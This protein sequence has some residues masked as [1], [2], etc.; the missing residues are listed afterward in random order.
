MRPDEDKTAAAD[1]GE[2]GVTADPR[3]PT[4]LAV[5]VLV[6]LLVAAGVGGYFLRQAIGEDAPQSVPQLASQQ[7]ERLTAVLEKDPD[8]V[9]ARLSLGYAHQSRQ[10]WDLALEQ[11]KAVAE[12]DPSNAGALYQQGVIYSALALDQE[13]EAAYWKVLEIDPEHVQAAI[14]LGRMYAEQ[15]NFRSIVS[16]VRPAVVAHP[17]SAE[18]QYLLGLAYEHTDH[19]D[20]AIARYNLSLQASPDYAEAHQG[21][22]RLGAR[23]SN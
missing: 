17:G 23:P 7:V 11:Y 19:E 21:L 13:A 20:W 14:A 3:V 16:A 22:T 15:E 4:W 18:L 6:A 8:N 2:S 5:L 1:A 12:K 9:E 10:E